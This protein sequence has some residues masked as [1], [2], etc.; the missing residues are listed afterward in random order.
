MRRAHYLLAAAAS[1]I[2]SACVAGPAP[3]IAT[4]PPILPESFAYAA[5]ASVAASVEALLPVDDA[6]FSE[7]SAAALANSPSLLE[8]AARVDSAV[9]NAGRTGANR[10]PLITGDSFT[11]AARTSPNQV[12]TNLPA[13]ISIDT[14]R[15]SYGANLSLVWDPDIYGQL[16]ASERSALSLA[17]AAGADAAAIRIAILAEIAGAVID[18]RT[19]AAREKALRED[20]VAA[21][22]L[23]ALTDIRE[24]AGIAPGF[25][26]VR[27]ETV[28]ETSLAR[29]TGLD[30]ERV[31]IIG[32]LV[33]LTAQSGQAVRASLANNAGAPAA[34]AAPTSTPSELLANRP[35][36]QAAAARLAASDA[37][38]YAVAA[39]RF[40]KCTLSAA[41]GLLA[42]DLGDL[43]DKD[44]VVGSAGR[45]LL[46]PLF[47]FGRIEAQIDGAAAAK[48][49]AF[50]SYRGS[51]FAALGEA[52]T[53][54]GLVASSDREL[55]AAERERASAQR[56]AELAEVRFRAGLA[57]FLTV[58]DARRIADSSGERVAAA[59]GRA[60][61]A[62]VLLW[63]ALGG[64]NGTA[65]DQ[66]ITLSTSQ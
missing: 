28:A 21:E 66:A 5:P 50:Q 30:S 52:E 16:R 61:R 29:I 36:I 9:A 37:E 34:L 47:D 22:S 57:N 17:D 10:K 14:E 58:L 39:N 46:A 49:A 20:L 31:R 40:P 4:P 2:L 44:A 23:V 54:Y 42:F 25:D 26:R 33:T 63:Q 6:A 65:G 32:R 1:L 12:G 64:N 27:A 53:A 43:F 59:R 11:T 15:V 48:R 24:R 45:S 38:L 41:L 55:D 56:A 19:L 60:L 51:I 7:L 35:D 3:D 18:W 13:G 8:A 62:R